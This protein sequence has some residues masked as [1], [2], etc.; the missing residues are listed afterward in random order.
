MCKPVI[1][2]VT[3]ETIAQ[4]ESGVGIYQETIK[5]KLLD[6][7]EVFFF[8]PAQAANKVAAYELLD[9]NYNVLWRKA[10]ADLKLRDIAFRLHHK[11][12]EQDFAE[13]LRRYNIQLVHFQ[14]LLVHIPYLP[15]VAKS[16]GVK[17]ILS[18]HDFYYLSPSF[19][20]IDKYGRF[21]KDFATSLDAEKKYMKDN[22]RVKPQE[23][24]MRKAF[25]TK[26]FC[27]VDLIHFNSQTTRDAYLHYF[28]NIKPEQYVTLGIPLVKI[29]SYQHK[30]KNLS[31]PLQIVVLGKLSENKGCDLLFALLPLLSNLNVFVHVYGE[32]DCVIT[33]RKIKAVKANNVK[34]YCQ[35]YSNSDLPRMLGDKDISLHLSICS[36][37]YSI[38]LSE[39]WQ[40]KLV[41][42]VHD[43][44]ELGNRVIHQK[45][46]F[47]VRVGDLKAIVAIILMLSKDRERLREIKRNITPDLYLTLDQHYRLLRQKYQDLLARTRDPQPD[48]G[49]EF[50]ITW[51]KKRFPVAQL[52]RRLFRLLK[53]YPQGVT[54]Q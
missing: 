8:A 26:L 18:V 39:V 2:I 45:N 37:T 16:T 35:R 42:I 30:N 40:A 49:D 41:P 22:H 48:A 27:A 23:Q 43:L 29:H 6:D 10:Y 53:L 1:L 44:G 28:K 14:H 11:V 34:F 54:G 47:K 25:Y 33:R 46:G 51:G 17:T 24:A 15:F 32:A 36:E 3:H 19:N 13:L 9:S 50:P 21:C 38:A 7:F 31:Q 20:L 5:T 52:Q 4:Q 12:L